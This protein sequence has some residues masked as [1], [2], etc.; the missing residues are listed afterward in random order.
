MCFGFPKAP[1]LVI[2]TACMILICSIAS[3]RALRIC[4]DPNNLPFSNEHCEGFENR[5]ADLLAMRR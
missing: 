4:A 1:A 3:A 5:I 2:A